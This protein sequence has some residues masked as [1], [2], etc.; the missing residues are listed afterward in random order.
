MTH[1]SWWTIDEIV[2]YDSLF[3]MIIISKQYFFL[4]YLD[5]LESDEHVQYEHGGEIFQAEG[6]GYDG[7]VR[8]LG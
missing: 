7:V 3:V 8:K 1:T 2:A 4:D 6:D 5:Y